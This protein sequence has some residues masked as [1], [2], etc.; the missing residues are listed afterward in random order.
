MLAKTETSVGLPILDWPKVWQ[1]VAPVV[2]GWGIGYEAQA[3]MSGETRY[4]KKLHER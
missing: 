2:P 4:V 3:I 1:K